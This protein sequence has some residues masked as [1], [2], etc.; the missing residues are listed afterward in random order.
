MKTKVIIAALALQ[1]TACTLPFGSM[2]VT[3]HGG[4]TSDVGKQSGGPGDG[5]SLR[6]DTGFGP[7]GKVLH[8]IGS[9]WDALRAVTYQAATGMLVAA[10]VQHR[11]RAMDGISDSDKF[12]LALT[13]YAA[14]G[15]VDRSFGG[16]N[17][18]VAIYRPSMGSDL[19][20]GGLLELPGGLLLV[21]VSISNGADVDIEL[22]RFSANGAFQGSLVT[23]DFGSNRADCV[24]A[25][26][27]DRDGRIHLAG[28][29]QES[30]PIGPIA[31][32]LVVA[33]LSPQPGGGFSLDWQYNMALDRVN[34]RNKF[35]T[36]GNSTANA[37]AIDSN[38]LAVVA[39]TVTNG[40]HVDFGVARLTTAGQLDTTFGAAATGAV[41]FD[42]GTSGDDHANAILITDS[43]RIVVAG[44]TVKDGRPRFGLACFLANGRL[45]T[46]FGQN[47]RSLGNFD[48]D[49]YATALVQRPDGDLVA[50]G[51]AFKESRYEFAA[52]KFSSQGAFEEKMGI[53]FG[54]DS[55]S[56]AAIRLA[57][58]AMVLVGETYNGLKQFDFSVAKIR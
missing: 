39:A 18:G 12:H 11:S 54:G 27:R 26:A 49:A 9:R 6:L 47:G 48:M 4:D 5:G 16:S 17:D 14:D 42:F 44:S 56:R 52:A 58:G 3:E 15:T 43:G 41:P 50:T 10:G 38:G 51:Y 2:K 21:A 7:D 22:L 29:S 31:S 40:N 34:G 24:K 55:Y 36:F 33:R 20:V 19:S 45:D 32:D 37:V 57:D 30:A 8:S 53:S 13:R 28:Y 46:Q 23:V 1:L 25:M 35:G